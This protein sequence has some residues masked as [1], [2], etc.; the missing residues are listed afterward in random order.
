MVSTFFLLF[1]ILFW[2]ESNHLFSFNY[3]FIHLQKTFSKIITHT[4]TCYSHRSNWRTRQRKSDSS[5]NLLPDM[6][7]SFTIWTST[8]SW[9]TVLPHTWLETPF[10]NEAGLSHFEEDTVLYH[11]NNNRLP[12]IRIE[13]VSHHIETGSCNWHMDIVSIIYYGVEKQCLAEFLTLVSLLLIF[14]PW[15]P[16][17][18]TYIFK[19]IDLKHF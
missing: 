16:F 12:P 3:H 8:A 9:E 10:Y 6:K 19:S 7:Q 4:G 14:S 5:L 18:R 17:T 15:T 2:I 1:P 11:Q 13:T